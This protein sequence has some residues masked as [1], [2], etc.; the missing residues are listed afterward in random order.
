ME[1]IRI[2]TPPS[3]AVGHPFERRCIAPSKKSC[4]A[5]HYQLPQIKQSTDGDT[6]L[7]VM[8]VNVMLGICCLE[9][10]R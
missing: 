2:R 3:D 4:Y 9:S 5:A 1:A 6:H 7:I 10:I 8:L